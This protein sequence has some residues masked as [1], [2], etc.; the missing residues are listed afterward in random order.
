MSSGKLVLVVEDDRECMILTREILR[1]A[2]YD[3]EAVENGDEAI[4][5][6]KRSRPDLILMDLDLPRVSGDKAIA[7]IRSDRG[8]RGTPI[9]AITAHTDDLLRRA[10]KAG[11]NDYIA[12]PFTPKTLLRAVQKTIG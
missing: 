7:K 8:S 2:G 3:V 1:R 12:K 5:S 4:K 9:I 11:C 10:M 6:A